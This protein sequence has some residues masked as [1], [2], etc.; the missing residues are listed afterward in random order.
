MADEDYE[1]WTNEQ[2]FEAFRNNNLAVATS[3]RELI[4]DAPLPDPRELA[5]LLNS[6]RLEHWD[7]MWQDEQYRKML[8]SNIDV[9]RAVSAINVENVQI[10]SAMLHRSVT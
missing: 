2:L 7:M 6:M 5:D 4:G 3:I 10:I 8:R 1:N 9:M